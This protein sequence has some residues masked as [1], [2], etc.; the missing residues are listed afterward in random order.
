MGWLRSLALGVAAA[1]FGGGCYLGFV[2][3]PSLFRRAAAGDPAVPDRAAA[4]DLL[5][6]LF[7]SFDAATV[8]AAGGLLLAALALRTGGVRLLGARRFAVEIVLATALAL[9]A[10][11]IGWLNPHAA[12]LRAQL[13]ATHGSYT[14]APAD[15][16]VKRSYGLAHGISTLVFCGVTLCAGFATLA[17]GSPARAPDA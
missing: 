15:D 13:K 2:L 9:G 10:L 11:G 6:P 1:W 4:G 17:L 7:R 12:A 5:A 16:P 3:A 14:Q 8:A